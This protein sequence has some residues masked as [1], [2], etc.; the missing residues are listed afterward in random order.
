MVMG[1]LA[2]SNASAIAQPNA[3]AVLVT[4]TNIAL[5]TYEDSLTA[6]KSLQAAVD[7]LLARPDETTLK[8]ARDAWIAARIP[9]QQSEVFRFGNPIVDAWEGQVNAWPLDEG[10]IDYV[11]TSQYGAQ[12]DENRFYAVNVIARKSIHI[13]GRMIDASHIDKSLLRNQLHELGGVEANVATGYHA[14]EFLLWGQDLNGN[15]PGAGARPATDYD[16]DHCSHG[17]CDRR[18]AYLKTATDLLVDDLAE[19]VAQW[20]D[21]GDARKSILNGDP[22]T[23]LSRALTGMGNLSFGELA[24]DRMKLGLMLHD[25]EEEHDCFS[26]NTHN[27]HFYSAL[28]IRNVYWGQYKRIDGSLVSGPSLSN[29]VAA[30]DAKLDTE[31]RNRLDA[32]QDAMAGLVKMAKAGKKYD[33]MIA[34]GD[35][36]GNRAIQNAITALTVQTKSIERTV[37]LLGLAKIKFDGPDTPG[38][39]FK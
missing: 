22:G 23:S 3:K 38:P 34:A 35:K 25:P 28:G 37:S 6:A 14:I 24:G 19:M 29:L 1:M 36:E 31:M 18:A 12:S 33:Q 27:S 9:Y 32:T 11:E 26:D 2:F 4:Y 13:G 15:G 17:N 20:R 30:R 5:T 16:P 8:A 21:T 10:L 39:V 7:S